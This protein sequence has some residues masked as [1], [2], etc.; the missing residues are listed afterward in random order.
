[1]HTVQTFF[2]AKQIATWFVYL[3]QKWNIPIEDCRDSLPIPETNQVRNGLILEYSRGLPS[4]LWT[5]WGRW[6]FLRSAALG[7]R[8]GKIILPQARRLVDLDLLW[9]P[10]ADDLEYSSLHIVHALKGTGFRLPYPHEPNPLRTA[11]EVLEE[12][13]LNQLLFDCSYLPSG[14]FR[15]VP[16]GEV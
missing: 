2:G 1:M 7:Y 4:T 14:Q 13:R 8:R 5:P 15:R 3:C 16:P 12:W 10:A 9:A 6:E 11:Q